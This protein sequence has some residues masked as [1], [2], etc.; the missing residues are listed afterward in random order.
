MIKEYI[1]FSLSSSG[2]K[3][4]DNTDIVAAAKDMESHFQ[5]LIGI[6]LTL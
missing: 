5:E 6:A 1:T 2:T 4:L 3:E